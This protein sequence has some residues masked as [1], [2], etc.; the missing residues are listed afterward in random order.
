MDSLADTIGWLTTADN[1]WGSTGILQRIW[2]H[3]QYSLLAVGL[4]VIIALPAGLV[5]GHTG[6]AE[7]GAVAV[8]GAARAVPTL[9]LLVL[10]GR[11]YPVQVWPVIVVL[12]VL[13]IPPILANT[14]AGIG[15][16]DP[17]ARDAARGMGMTPMQVLTQVEVPLAAPLILAGVRSAL[18]QVIATAT[19]AAFAGLGGLGRFVIDGFAVSDDARVYGGSI[20]VAVLALVSEGLFA[21]AQLV[22]A[23][24]PASP[25]GTGARRRSPCPTH[26]WRSQHMKYTRLLAALAALALVAAA[27]GDDDDDDSA[28]GDDAAAGDLS[29]QSLTIGSAN[30]PESVLLAEI[31]AGALEA[32]GADV[33]VEP[34]IGSP[35]GLLPGHRNRR[36]RPAA[37]VHEL[38]AFVCAAP[39][40]S[41]SDSRGHQCR[42]AARRARGRAARQ[43]DRPDAV[44]RRGQGRHRLQPGDDRRVRLLR[45]QRP[46]RGV[47]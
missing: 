26:S 12:A 31:Y 36:D 4:A 39:G 33:T 47:G 15:N 41:R 3:L 20:V 27:C 40:R 19:I 35:R 1:W 10:L 34:N 18:L 17:A 11:W 37:G 22:R 43:P 32:E 8:S 14:T 24:Y 46:R 21:L 13:A 5:I 2:E 44:N 23:A 42:G 45:S 29:G 16:I 30:F 7:P 6:R 28:A 25:P 38:P 9:G